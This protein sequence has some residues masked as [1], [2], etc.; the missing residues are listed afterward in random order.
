VVR[1]SGRLGIGA[2]TIYAFST[3]NWKRPAEEVNALMELFVKYIRS[4]LP[5]LHANG[6]R[7][8][9]IGRRSRFKPQILE[10]MEAAEAHT[11]QNSGL[12]LNIA[13]DYGGRDELTRAVQ[14][15]AARVA[16]GEVAPEA[17]TEQ[18]IADHLDT[19]GL[20]DPDLLIRTG[21]DLRLSNFLLYQCS[22]SELYI[23][24]TYWPDFDAAAYHEA[25]RV[26]QSRQRRF[27]KV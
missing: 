20:D 17:I 15:L 24:E 26:F 1:E 6:V 9:F 7:L 21:G 3:E 4:E 5:E 8:R 14:K 23:P 13:V 25:I 16:A 11:A 2:L 19:A 12:T 22:Y 27:G 10:A 18:M